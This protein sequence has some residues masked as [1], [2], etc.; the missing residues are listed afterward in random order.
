MK[1]NR[2]LVADAAVIGP[3][4]LYIVS[5]GI[6]S[7]AQLHKYNGIYGIHSYT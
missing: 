2:H 7:E 4:S 6:S 5:C 3:C 1:V